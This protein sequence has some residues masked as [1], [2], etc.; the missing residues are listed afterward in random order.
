MA[1]A[2]KLKRTIGE[3]FYNKF[4]VIPMEGYGATELSPAV[5]MGIPDF[6]S[7]TDSERQ[8]GY[9]EGKVG[10]PLPGV[11]VKI[12]DPD[13]FNMLSTDEEGLLLVKGPNV[14]KGYLN[15]LEKTKEVIKDGWYVTGDIATVDKDGFLCIT[16]RLSRFSKIAGEMVPHIKIEETILNILDTAEPVCAVTSLADEKRGERLVVLYKGDINIEELWKKLNETSLPKLWIPREKSFYKVEDI[17]LLGSG[18]FD[19]K[20]IKV[21][22][23][24]IAKEKEARND[25]VS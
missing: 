20:K 7:E 12:V 1:G 21:M 19:L 17:P 4:N 22:A 10:H 3:A 25:E 13:T 23:Q 16:D 9:K 2:E 5:S 6:V 14:M 18:K 15:D 24:E 11:A 8:V